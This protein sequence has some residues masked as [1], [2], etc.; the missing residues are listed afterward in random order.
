MRKT[1]VTFEMASNGCLH[2]NRIFIVEG[3][4]HKHDTYWMYLHIDKLALY[5]LN[6]ILVTCLLLESSIC[7]RVV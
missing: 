3:R 1:T 2:L 4:Q 6:I 5:R 7:V